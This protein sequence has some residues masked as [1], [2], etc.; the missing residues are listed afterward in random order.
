MNTLGSRI[1]PAGIELARAA[2]AKVAHEFSVS[3]KAGVMLT[4]SIA[5]GLGNAYSDIDLEVVDPAWKAG[6]GGRHY[7]HLDG[8][9]IEIFFWTPSELERL[10]AEIN[11]SPVEQWN[12]ETLHLL[13]RYHHYCYAF[14]VQNPDLVAAITTAFSQTALVTRV[15]AVC[16]GQAQHEACLGRALMA[17]VRN[18]EAV[19][20]L[21]QA[22]ALAAASWAGSRGETFLGERPKWLAPLLV[23]AGLSADLYAKYQTFMRSHEAS[24]DGSVEDRCRALFDSLNVSTDC[25][26]A[27][28]SIQLGEN[29]RA[30]DFGSAVHAVR[31]SPGEPRLYRLNDRASLLWRELQSGASQPSNLRTHSKYSAEAGSLH[32]HGLV[33][34]SVLPWLRDWVYPT[35][36]TRGEHVSVC[37]DGIKARESS[38]VVLAD[39]TPEVFARAG[40]ALLTAAFYL[41]NVREDL[42]GALDGG[43]W[44]V[45]EVALEWAVGWAAIAVL[46][47]QGICLASP[48]QGALP[49][50][51]HLPGVAPE[52]FDE[53]HH[54]ARWPVRDATDAH[55]A[56]EALHAWFETLPIDILDPRVARTHETTIGF[57]NILQLARV[58]VPMI[59]DLGLPLPTREIEYT[60][61]VA[62]GEQ[63]ARMKMAAMGQMLGWRRELHLPGAEPTVPKPGLEL[64]SLVRS[65][66][67]TW[68]SL[69][70]NGKRRP[71]RS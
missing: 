22:A 71:T 68:R 15:V 38:A 13:K 35:M 57:L 5:E 42:A 23:R 29:V 36:P 26:D 49:A 25:F 21:R 46:A 48:T 62:E 33:R 17:V 53:A 12:Y 27:T 9:R 18:R 37:F 64:V 44:A 7:S 51:E 28:I 30:W 56:L 40:G 61:A 50:L 52:L 39:M 58:W 11:D 70:A 1:Q 67:R 59:K 4:G 60:L 65:S 47:S 6:T 2:F 20:H 54:I 3:E 63:P 10:A 8:Q 45:L 69:R 32:L 34:L 19:Y 43:Q 31:Q 14:P 66:Y 41:A 24:C 55:A 16:A